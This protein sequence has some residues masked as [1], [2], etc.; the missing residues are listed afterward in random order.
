MRENQSPYPCHSH[1][2]QHTADCERR[3]LH[4][5]SEGTLP[6]QATSDVITSECAELRDECERLRTEYE[7]QIEELE[8]EIERTHREKRLVLEQREEHTELVNAVKEEQ[9]LAKRKAQAGLWTKTK[10]ALF[11]MRDEDGD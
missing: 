5:V 8:R 4:K 3:L 11:G 2:V 10:W 9:S 1:L 7:D 6:S